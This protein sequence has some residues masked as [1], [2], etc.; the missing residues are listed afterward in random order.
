MSQYVARATGVAKQAA[1]TF[2]KRVVPPAVDYYNA[3]MAR[4]A[5]YVVKDPAA[6]DKLGRQ[7]VF[8]NLAKLPGMVEGA[9]AEVN[10]V[11]QKW[12][13]RMDLPMA[14]VG[15]AALFA[16]EVYAWFCVGEIIGRGGSL[17][18]Y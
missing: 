13:G 18:G 2:S 14:E 5:E 11:K 12:A 1:E 8:S 15:T 9:R 7:L 6:V 4:N 16:G 10:I 3:T 17:T